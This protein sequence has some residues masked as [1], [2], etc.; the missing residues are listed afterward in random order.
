[1]AFDKPYVFEDATRS[2]GARPLM[3]S[4]MANDLRDWCRGATGALLL[5]VIAAVW[6]SLISWS[7][8]DPSYF[9]ATAR[10]ARNWLGS[11]GAN[12][13]DLIL[14]TFGVAAP[15]LLLGPMMWALAFI[16]KDHVGNLGLRIAAYVAS[17][18]LLAAAASAVPQP[19][20]WPLH[21]G[22]GGIAGDAVFR[23]AALPLAIVSAELGRPLASVLLLALGGWL[24]SASLGIARPRYTSPAA[25][26]TRSRAVTITPAASQSQRVE[27]V[28]TVRPA[29]AAATQSPAIA[30]IRKD[31]FGPYAETAFEPDDAE[32]VD[33]EFEAWTN[34]VSSGIAARF[35]PQ[36][37]G[38]EPKA[39]AA[40][41]W[42]QT[43]QP[44][45]NVPHAMHGTL[46]DAFAAPVFDEVMTPE[47]F[48]P[49]A[50]TTTSTA[51]T[52]T[53]PAAYKRPSLNLLERPVTSR[54]K[55]GYTQA[56]LRGN[57]RLLED[58]LADFGVTGEIRDIV[59]GPVVTIYELEPARGTNP[60]RVISLSD[61]I[62]RGM[63]VPSVR[64]AAIP[65]RTALSVE[66]PNQ[67]RE[68]VMLRDVFDA[69][70]YRS[71]MDMLPVALG[72]NVEGR[73]IVA[74]L[75][76]TPHIL[77]AGANGS[78]KSTGVNA[79]ILSLLYKHG[80]DDCR[81]LMIDPK[82]L[83][84]AAYNGI[85]H[86]LTPVVTDPHKA[87][88]ALAWCVTEMEQRYKRM[89]ALGVRN[90]DVFNNRVRNAKKRGE[91]LARTVQT[92]FDT[93]TGQ[94][95]YVQE[96]MNLEP[97]PFIV[98]VMDEFADLMAVAGRD[99]EGAVKRLAEAA[100]PA[101]IHLIMATERPTADIV[102]PGL[103]GNLAARVS[104][105]AASKLDSRAV[106]G[107][108][109]AE[110]LLGSGDLLYANGTG[111]LQR[112]HGPYVS[113]DEINAVA[114]SLRQQSAPRYIDG[115]TGSESD[116]ASNP[117]RRGADP[118]S[119]RPGVISTSDDA[120]YDRA[121][122]TIIRDRHASNAHLQRRLNISP[123]WAAAL[124]Q[125]LEQ[126]GLI[127]PPDPHGNHQV[128]VGAA[129]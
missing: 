48:E 125:R 4:A 28:L 46:S 21:A 49:T 19:A 25:V 52:R 118:S 61:D 26:R 32:P 22:L 112:I 53:Q 89:A 99:I 69:D 91:R 44:A 101:G 98:I 35:A 36:N 10:S 7:Y 103:K 128:R 33:H 51:L 8:Q 87:I 37:A 115:I 117:R 42:L 62:A 122:A 23:A 39:P 16:Q 45:P 47:P 24:A 11:P 92:G 129:A 2:G 72:R 76:R 12:T 127:G 114:S 82:M 88:T 55:P 14:Q 6:L 57:A 100:K 66:L 29:A 106:L 124:L 83:D 102:T 79:M 43:G 94:A 68:T 67:V 109:G 120:L 3:P 17:M 41:G 56:M 93:R 126:S 107:T 74:D 75:A 81:F 80:P 123:A 111:A 1:M 108:E 86:L 9:H 121:V 58:V 73:P 95:T 113:Q 54:V 78:G 50:R 65:G 105:K 59:P 71:T 64:I 63:S 119:M 18:V 116:P 84:L 97:M 27:P 60:A 85:P 13:A 15:A 38:L 96:E 20:S 104:Y 30:A 77:V 31:R 110:Q 90:I 40:T 34:A 5:I 70:V